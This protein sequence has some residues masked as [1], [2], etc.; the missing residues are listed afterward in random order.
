MFLRKEKNK[1]GGISVQIIPKDR[2]SVK[3]N[4]KNLRMFLRKKKNKSGSISVQIIPKDRGSVMST[5]NVGYSLIS[6]GQDRLQIARPTGSSGRAY[7]PLPWCYEQA[8]LSEIIEKNFM[9]S[10]A[11]H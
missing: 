3:L 2:G 11:E 1:S 5:L 9:V 6:N 4:M 7:C 8:E 10:Q